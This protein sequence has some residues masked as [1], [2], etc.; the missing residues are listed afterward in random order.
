MM[1]VQTAMMTM[2]AAPGTSWLTVAMSWAPTIELTEDQPM[3]ARTLKKATVAYQSVPGAQHA[4]IGLDI[5]SLTP[6]HPY[7]K[8]ESTI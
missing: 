2:P 6:Y 7:Q 1:K 8:R 3:Q 5:L 4:E